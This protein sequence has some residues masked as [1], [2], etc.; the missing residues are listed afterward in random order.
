MIFF[1]YA[2]RRGWTYFTESLNA[3]PGFLGTLC[4]SWDDFTDG[5]C[6]GNP[7]AAFGIGDHSE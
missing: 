2:C 7:Q 4:D 5:K 3:E 1:F 6:E